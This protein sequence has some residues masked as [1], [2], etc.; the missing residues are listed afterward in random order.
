MTKDYIRVL[1]SCLDAKALTTKPDGIKL[2]IDEVMKI[3]DGTESDDILEE[4]SVVR[5]DFSRL[6]SRMRTLTV[7]AIEE[8]KNDNGMEAIDEDTRRFRSYVK[9]VITKKYPAQITDFGTKLA[10]AIEAVPDRMNYRD[11][12]LSRKDHNLQN[13]PATL[14]S[15]YMDIIRIFAGFCPYKL[16]DKD[17][18]E[19]F[20]DT[21]KELVDR[22][23]EKNQDELIKEYI[24]TMTCDTSKIVIHVTEIEE[25]VQRF[26]AQKKAPIVKRDYTKAT[27]A[28]RTKPEKK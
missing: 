13:Y 2:K 25:F 15:M 9:D 26:N 14:I 17:L 20:M 1:I 8:S 7:K 6:V 5:D 4:L 24:S 16:F 3:I 19:L 18:R 27:F 10:D 12:T 22:L 23:V 28:K 11:C 21:G